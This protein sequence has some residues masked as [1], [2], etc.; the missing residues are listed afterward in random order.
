[1]QII[2][3]T[4]LLH[5]LKSRSVDQFHVFV[6]FEKRPATSLA[7]KVGDAVNKHM[8]KNN[9]SVCERERER[10][11]EREGE[12]KSIN[13]NSNTCTVTRKDI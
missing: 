2:L 9:R 6:D 1:M 7:V 11:R 3:Y 12:R 4:L 10:E 13:R 5:L 8:L